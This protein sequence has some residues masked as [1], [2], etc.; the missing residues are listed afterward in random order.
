MAKT[1]VGSLMKWG[2]IGIIFFYVA[3]NIIPKITGFKL[4]GTSIEDIQAEQQYYLSTI[5]VVEANKIEQEQIMQQLETQTFSSEYAQARIIEF[6]RWWNEANTQYWEAYN[7]KLLYPWNE[8]VKLRADTIMLDTET[9]MQIY[10]E[11]IAFFKQF[12]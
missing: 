8:G 4:P 9:K 10:G 1:D 5:K 11:K 6:E 3:K 12:V 2:V 7:M